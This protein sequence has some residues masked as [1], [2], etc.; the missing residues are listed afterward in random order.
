MQQKSS[1][2]VMALLIAM[3]SVFSIEYVNAQ[4]ELLPSPLILPGNAIYFDGNKTYMEVPDDS[5]LN[6]EGDYTVELLIRP[7]NNNQCNLLNKWKIN[8]GRGLAFIQGWTIDL[9]RAGQKDFMTSDRK[10]ISNGPVQGYHEPGVLSFIVSWFEESN[11]HI[12]G[13]WG[14]TRFQGDINAGNWYHIALTLIK[15]TQRAKFYV[16]G[17]YLYTIHQ[18]DFGK[19]LSTTGFPLRIGGNPDAV[20]T[21]GDSIIYFNG[22]MDE[23]RIWNYARSQNDIQSMM[24][25]TLS[26]DYYST[27]EKGLIAY[28]RFDQFENLGINDD[29]LSDDVRDLS[30]YQNHGDLVGNPELEMELVATSVVYPL[31]KIPES[32]DLLQNFPNPFNPSTTIRFSL[33]EPTNVK[34]SIYDV[35]GKEIEV[36]IDQHLLSGIHETI[37]TVNDLPSGIYV[38]RL[39]TEKFSKFSKMLF[40]K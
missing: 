17:E 14:L 18:G 32:Y 2:L 40:Q 12:H 24:F 4:D 8:R 19:N 11:G 29:G 3:F 9:N 26:N 20:T 21:T 39:E 34:L 15:N 25:D 16:N 33:P 13:G 5:I 28:Y 30:V 6:F 37:W 23:L 22:L 35:L 31:D 36:L 7:N 27:S 38:Y 1:I 10:L